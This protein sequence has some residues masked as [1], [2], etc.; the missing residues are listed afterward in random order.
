MKSLWILWSLLELSTDVRPDRFFSGGIIGKEIEEILRWDILAE[1]VN[2]LGKEEL[3]Y[4]RNWR[5]LRLPDSGEIGF[6]IETGCRRGKIRFS[7]PRSGNG[8]IVV[9]GPLGIGVK[10]HG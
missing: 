5:A 9:H 2:A 3:A 7:V 4:L 6:A 1:S 8:R 10:R